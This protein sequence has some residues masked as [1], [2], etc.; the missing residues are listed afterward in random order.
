M[1]EHTPQS[2]HEQSDIRPDTPGENDPGTGRRLALDVGTVR[3]G[4]AYS[5]R[6]AVL[7][8]PLETVQRTTKFQDPDGSDI[9][10][11]LELVREHQIVEV[12]VGLPRN[13]DGSGSSSVRHAQDIA[14]RLELQLSQRSPAVP[15]RFADERLTTV[16]AHQTMKAT[17]LSQK[18]GRKVV[19]QIAAVNILQQWLDGRSRT[20]ARLAFEAEQAEQAEWLDSP[21]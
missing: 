10:R 20:L 14:R 8:N 12:V 11:I 4:V 6:A 19:D 15:V 3:I 16:M 17:G 7:A 1:V 18:K 9:Q 21:E 5:D 2:Q 13:L